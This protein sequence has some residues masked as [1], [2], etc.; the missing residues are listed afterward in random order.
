MTLY[1]NK[2]I[3][4]GKIIEIKT[5]RYIT[6]QLSVNICNVYNVVR[7]FKKKIYGVCCSLVIPAKEKSIDIELRRPEDEDGVLTDS[8]FGEVG[9][10]IFPL[11]RGTDHSS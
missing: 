9:D 11:F 10:E 4:C 5:C 3:N 1:I 7:L 8:A 2:K 6:V